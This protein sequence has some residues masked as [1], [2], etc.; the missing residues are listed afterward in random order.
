MAIGSDNVRDSLYPFGD[1]DMVENF[2]QSMAFYHL[3]QNIG[4]SLA[5]IGPMP[6]LMMGVSPV[7]SLTTGRPANL[8][9]FD[10][11]NLGEIVARPQ[12]N[13]VVLLNGRHVKDTLPEFPDIAGRFVSP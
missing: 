9:I 10:A 6:G 2:R 13:R 5:M 12:M 3:D 4:E 1:Y 7:G 8:I 11:L